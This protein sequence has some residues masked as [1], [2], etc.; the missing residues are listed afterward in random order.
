MNTIN[1]KP[2]QSLIRTI[3]A[4][5]EYVFLKIT[6]EDHTQVE[7]ERDSEKFGS[8]ICNYISK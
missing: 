5:N 2:L 6:F 1:L 8:S 4:T 7:I 3:K